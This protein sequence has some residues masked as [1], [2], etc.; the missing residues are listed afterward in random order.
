LTGEHAQ[1][2]CQDCHL[3][4]PDGTIL[5]GTPQEC[6][7]CHA[8]D[9]AHQGGLGQ[10]CAVCHTP[11]GWSET[12]FDH[13]QSA[14]PLAGQHV[15]VACN[16]CHL[17]SPT[18]RI[19]RGTPTL[20]GACHVQDDPHNGEFGQQCDACHT[21]DGW[22]QVTFDH[23]KSAFPLDGA[24]QDL[25]CQ[26]CH[27]TATGEMVFRGTP[28]ECAGCHAEPAYHLGVFGQEC[29][30]CHTTSAWQPAVFDGPHTFPINHGDSGNTCRD[31][32]SDTLSSYTC[33]TCHSDA[34]MAEEHRKEGISNIRDCLSCHPTGQK[35]EG[36]GGGDD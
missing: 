14:F 15:Q 9:D 26:D 5:R 18:G 3:P 1:V 12:S 33:A 32:H 30:R 34:E 10:D 20:C 22:E 6:Y 8:A 23:S 4:G 25:L 11:D 16:D 13:S 7:A 21:V 19:F 27:Q 17:E 29:Q 31:C 2:A 24:H 28:L 35:D 36:R